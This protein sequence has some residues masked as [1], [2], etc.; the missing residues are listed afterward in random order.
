M[1][2]LQPRASSQGTLGID[3]SGFHCGYCFLLSKNPPSDFGLIDPSRKLD[4]WERQL[5]IV[6]QLAQLMDD[7]KPASVVFETIR[8]FH[9]GGI[10]LPAIRDLARLSG[11]IGLEATRRRVEIH[12]THTGHWR[13]RVLGDGRATKEDVIKWVEER[14]GISAEA[15]VAEAIALAV[16]GQLIRTKRG[17]RYDRRM[18]SRR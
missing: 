12:E 18:A 8:L 10:S 13:K 14:Y 11:A 9:H 7:H 3:L 5:L 17:G 15:D 2:L 4:Y 1:G 6:N 16:Y